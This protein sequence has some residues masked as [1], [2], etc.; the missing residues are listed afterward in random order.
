MDNYGNISYAYHQTVVMR[1]FWL[2]LA[3]EKLAFGSLASPQ[4]SPCNHCGPEVL[5]ET[6]LSMKF[7]DDDDAD[8]VSMA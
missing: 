4:A 6:C 1:T 3:R 8:H 7:V 5:F 2:T